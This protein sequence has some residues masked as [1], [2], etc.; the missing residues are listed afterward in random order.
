MDEGG[1][2]PTTNYRD[3]FREVEARVAG[4][5]QY[6]TQSPL[7]LQYF[8]ESLSLVQLRES[9][10]QV[11]PFNAGPVHTLISEER[12]RYLEKFMNL[13]SAGEVLEQF[14]DIVLRDFVHYHMGFR[15][16]FTDDLARWEL[17]RWAVR[18]SVALCRQNV[19]V[20]RFE[21]QYD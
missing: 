6:A 17:E 3:R 11:R 5:Q 2:N 14:P 8:L 15:V 16:R 7:I 12:D 1:T 21:G 18:F 4:L 10:I 20:E 9:K 13:A 19:T